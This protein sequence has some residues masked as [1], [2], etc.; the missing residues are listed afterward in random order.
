VRARHS[1][2]GVGSQQLPGRVAEPKRSPVFPLTQWRSRQV[3]VSW[4]LSDGV[5]G[6]TTGPARAWRRPPEITCLCGVAGG[7]GWRC[8]IDTSIRLVY[9]G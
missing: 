6:A 2:A 4:T 9:K 1:G 5:G 3:T 7:R 8:S